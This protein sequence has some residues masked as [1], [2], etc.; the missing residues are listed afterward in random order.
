MTDVVNTSST[1]IIVRRLHVV[2][3]H[4]GRFGTQR[5]NTKVADSRFRDDGVIVRG[6]VVEVGRSLSAA[7]DLLQASVEHVVGE[8]GIIVDRIVVGLDAVGV[9]DGEFG[10]PAGLHGFV[11]DA[12]ANAQTIEVE[13]VPDKAA[14][15]DG[16]VLLVEI[17]VER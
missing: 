6:A 4:I 16:C 13:R 8:L 11:D 15:L 1:V 10:I 14:V 3:A 12:V 5:S 17:V 2:T 9:V 7:L